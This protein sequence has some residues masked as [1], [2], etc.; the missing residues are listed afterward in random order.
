[1]ALVGIGSA[2]G[3][4]QLIRAA[5]GMDLKT[6][7]EQAGKVR[8]TLSNK[9]MAWRVLS[10]A[11]IGHELV[12]DSWSQLAEIHAAPQWLWAALVQQMVTDS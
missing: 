4:G 1:M 7:A 3:H 2:D 6:Y 9:V 12:R 10:V 5:T 11:D 8:K